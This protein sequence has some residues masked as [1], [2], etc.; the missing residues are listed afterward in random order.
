[1]TD[2]IGSL[3]K[4]ADDLGRLGEDISLGPFP[5]LVAILHLLANFGHQFRSEWNTIASIELIKPSL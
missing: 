1:M 2:W 3:V 5:A 4:D